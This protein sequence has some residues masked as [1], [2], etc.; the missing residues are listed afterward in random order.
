FKK[1]ASFSEKVARFLL[2]VGEL[3]PK[4]YFAFYFFIKRKRKIGSK[5]RMGKPLTRMKKPQYNGRKNIN[6]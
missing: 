2:K 3:F 4:R 6:L 5:E 1:Q